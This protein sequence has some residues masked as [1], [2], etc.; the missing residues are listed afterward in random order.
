MK[1]NKQSGNVVVGMII[2]IMAALCAWMFH[3]QSEHDILFARWEGDC[4]VLNGSIREVH[5][6]RW[7]CF[8]NNEKVVVPGYERYQ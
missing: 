4:K 1:T 3:M 6:N 8:V 7:E 2:F 5:P